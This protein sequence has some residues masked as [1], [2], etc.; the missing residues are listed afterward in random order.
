M[1]VTV[2]NSKTVLLL[3]ILQYLWTVMF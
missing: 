1:E 3:T 2:L